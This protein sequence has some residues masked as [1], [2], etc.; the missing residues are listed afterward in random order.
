VVVASTAG[1]FTPAE[2]LVEGT[3]VGN[4]QRIGA[5]QT[6]QGPIDVTTHGAGVLAEW[7]VTPDD[8]VAPGQPLARIGDQL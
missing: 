5:V 2:G 3:E 1:T 4:G 6:S 7:L 8:P